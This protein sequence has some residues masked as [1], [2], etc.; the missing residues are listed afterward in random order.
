[1][2]IA[3]QGSVLRLQ[4]AMLPSLGRRDERRTWQPSMSDIAQTF[5]LPW[6]KTGMSSKLTSKK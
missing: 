5:F 6:F 3:V 4:P 1:M 2:S